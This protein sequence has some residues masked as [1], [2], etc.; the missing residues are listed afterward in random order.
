[1]LMTVKH[2]MKSCEKGPWSSGGWRHFLA[3]NQESARA[4]VDLVSTWYLDLTDLNI[5]G[6][7]EEVV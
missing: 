2:F 5:V 1:M 6:K 4:A 7:V 3:G